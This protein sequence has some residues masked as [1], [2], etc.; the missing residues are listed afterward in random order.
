MSHALGRPPHRVVRTVSPPAAPMVTTARILR[1]A[2]GAALSVA[3]CGCERA[4]K[5]EAP[6]TLAARTR[7]WTLAASSKAFGADCRD[8]GDFIA[9]FEPQRI[10]ALPRALPALGAPSSLGFRCWEGAGERTCVDRLRG[11]GPF[12]CSAE[13]G[14]QTSCLQRAPRLPRGG[15][16]D[17]GDDDGAVVCLGQDGPPVVDPAWKC[18]P[19]RGAAGQRVCVDLSPD[20]PDGRADG[21]DCKLEDDPRA[22]GG[23]ARRCERDPQVRG[24][25]ASCDAKRPCVIGARC[26]SGA[27]LPNAPHADCIADH[28]CDGDVCRFGTCLARGVAP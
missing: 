10:R 19:R 2:L 11:A 13:K 15:I 25:G 6:P 5:D 9:C 4:A 7:R 17:C 20:Y 3:P 8:V 24:V 14:V 22:V 23:R 28:D 12:V 16:W 1:F 26:V 21:W 27:C 18:G